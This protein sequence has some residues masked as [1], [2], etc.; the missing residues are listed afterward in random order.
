MQSPVAK[1]GWAHRF[2]NSKLPEISILLLATL[3]RSWRLDYHSLWF[4]EAVS[5][6][7]A[8]SAA[9][10]IWSVTLQLVQEKHPPVY[11]LVLHYWAAFL[12]LFG[13]HTNDVAL[14]LLG[15]LFGVATVGLLMGLVHAQ[16]GR[17]TALLAGALV[18]VSPVL[19]WYS[20]ELRMFQPATTAIVAAA[21][22]LWLAWNGASAR[23]RLLWWGL[24]VIA[25]LFALYSYLFSAFVLPAAGLSLLGLW[26]LETLGNR[27]RRPVENRAAR[28]APLCR[29]RPCTP[30]H[31]GPLSSAGTQCLALECQ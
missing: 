14:R 3:T 27:Q 6:K 1:T 30:C 4:D 23:R 2:L 12:E 29:R 13:L 10:Y 26:W 24:M 11:Y 18:A 7:W 15:V 21:C 28:V 22:C 16:S 17:T 20:Q 19:V 25:W 5:M 31:R 9:S 8:R